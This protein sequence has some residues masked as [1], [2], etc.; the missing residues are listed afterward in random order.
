MYLN[1]NPSN[2]LKEIISM[3]YWSML[4]ACTVGPGTV[5]TCARAGAEFELNLIYVL[6]FASCLAYTLQE[7]TARLTI[8]SGLS[9]GQCLRRKFEH[10]Y[11]IYNS[12]LICWVVA[13]CVTVGNTLYEC[14]NFAGGID[15]VMSFPGADELQR[16]ATESHLGPTAAETGLRVGSCFAYAI[17]VLALLYKDKTNILGVFLGVIMMGMVTLFLIVV[18]VMGV[19]WKKFAWGLIPNYPQK[20]E[21]ADAV[22]PADIIISLVGTTSI[23]FNLFL[24]GAMAKGRTLGSAQR[25]IAFSTISAF[26]VSVLILTVGAGYHETRTDSNFSVT[27]LAKFIQQF[28]GIIGV[29]IYSVGF[30]AAALSSMLTVPLGAA[31]T[32]D[33]VFSDDVNDAND[34][35][36]DDA[37]RPGDAYAVTSDKIPVPTSP[38]KVPMS[39]SKSDVNIPI[40]PPTSPEKKLLSLSPQSLHIEHEQK[41]QDG[42]ADTA[43]SSGDLQPSSSQPAELGLTIDN[44]TE[45]PNKL[46]RW[47]YLSIMFVMVII[48]VVV[49]SANADRTYV[50]LVA[51]VFNGC[52]LPFFST[53]LLLCLN[54]QQFMKTS[55]QPLW[56]NIFLVTSVLITMFLAN[57]A[58]M[59]EIFGDMLQSISIR[60]GVAVGAAFFEMF[61][62]SVLTSLGKDLWRSFRESKLSLLCFVETN[63]TEEEMRSDLKQLSKV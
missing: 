14:N 53:C 63:N 28:V 15:A 41:Q 48:S 26:V 36:A 21:D 33:S 49:I 31:L 43:S 3:L 38:S 51:Q 27:D 7:G 32:A 37:D 34:A 13:I 22:E 40:S 4:A 19:D 58:L 24:G 62:V 55:P 25:G 23:G 35:E 42:A 9:L 5:V 45:E 44:Q 6:I 1:V 57:N 61:L 47:I 50:I 56:A 46:P 20:G 8:N 10:T 11:K 30:I 16:N 12:A 2:L 17:V 29:S 60:L 54:D 59:Q 39:P 18:G 52:L